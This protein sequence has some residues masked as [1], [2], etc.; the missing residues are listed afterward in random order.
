M[1]LC[2][3][4]CGSLGGRRLGENECMYM[5]MAESLFSSSE[6]LET[7]LAGYAPIKIKKILKKKKKTIKV[8][9][10]HDLYQISIQ[11]SGS[12]RCFMDYKWNHQC[13]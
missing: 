8:S 1:E 3:M 2:S 7:F 11:A 12:L 13:K 6:T 9:Q 10:G 5:Y 4:L